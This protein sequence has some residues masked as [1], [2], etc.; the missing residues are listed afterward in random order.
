MLNDNDN[1]N[2]NGNENKNNVINE[3]NNNNNTME[4][5]L[6]NSKT[7]NDFVYTSTETQPDISN[8]VG[9]PSTKYVS[10]DTKKSKVSNPPKFS[11]TRSRISVAHERSVY[12]KT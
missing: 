12:E 2:D 4:R 5:R 9:I 8:D 7:I 1:D 3:N 11:Q 6:K 10:M